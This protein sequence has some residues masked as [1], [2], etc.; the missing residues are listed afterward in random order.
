MSESTSVPEQWSQSH[1]PESSAQ[2]SLETDQGEE[3]GPAS[4]GTPSSTVHAALFKSLLKPLWV[5]GA[6]VRPK[7][8]RP[9]PQ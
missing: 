3:R 6:A 9:K 7:P 1:P 4:T 2:S 5:S 8:R